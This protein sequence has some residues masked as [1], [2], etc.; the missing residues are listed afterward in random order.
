MWRYFA[1]GFVA[2]LIGCGDDGDDVTAAA[3]IGSDG[4]AADASSGRLPIAFTP[5][6]SGVTYIAGGLIRGEGDEMFGYSP[7]FL[8]RSTDLGHT[9]Q[10]RARG[11]LNRLAS[12]HDGTLYTVSAS[13][14][15]RSRDDGATVEALALRPER[16]PHPPNCFDRRT[17]AI[18]SSRSRCPRRGPTSGCSRATTG[19]ST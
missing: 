4:D 13:S 14:L 16:R 17:A 5:I 18:R 6:A 2:A 10:R 19:C 1:A 9:W 3:H 11:E 15:Y 12:D 8:E 7:G